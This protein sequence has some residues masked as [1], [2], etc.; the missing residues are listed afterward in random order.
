MAST[1]ARILEVAERVFIEHGY[2]AATMQDVADRVGITKAAL[3]YHF[4]SKAEILGSL[5]DPLTT[6]LERILADAV[7]THSA[8]GSHAVRAALLTGWLDVFLRSRRTLLILFRQLATV[9]TGS[10][11]RLIVVIES[12]IAAAAGPGVA[13]RVAVIQAISAITDPVAFLPDL[14][15]DVLRK[16]L[17]AGV[18]RLLGES[19]E[20]ARGTR[21]RPRALS[22]DEVARLRELHASAGRSADEIAAEL[23]VSR[24]T[25]YRYLKNNQNTDL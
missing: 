3:Y 13:E 8:E 5:L 10:F 4:T 22:T 23:G 14:P 21:G 16:H 6:D 18:W 17:L 15:D 20:P 25:V 1:K 9:S 24:A 7:A 11:D 12:A 19:P 2:H